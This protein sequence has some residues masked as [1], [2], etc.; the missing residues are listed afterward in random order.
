MWFVISTALKSL[1]NS[2]MHILNHILVGH[3]QR[4]RPCRFY[5]VLVQRNPSELGNPRAGTRVGLVSEVGV[6]AGQGPEG[7]LSVLLHNDVIPTERPAKTSGSVFL[8]LWS[9]TRNRSDCSPLLTPQRCEADSQNPELILGLQHVPSGELERHLHHRFDV[10]IKLG[11]QP[12]PSEPFEL[13]C[14]AGVNNKRAG[15]WEGATTDGCGRIQPTTYW[16]IVATASWSAP[17]SLT[18]KRPHRAAL[19]QIITSTLYLVTESRAWI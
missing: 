1:L 8:Y 18:V 15:S 3:F 9:R 6:L 17:W 16:S 13:E 5:P 7:D 11:E 10:L 4:S 14:C 19:F 2:K 12:G